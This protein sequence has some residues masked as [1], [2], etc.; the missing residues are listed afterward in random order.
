MEAVSDYFTGLSS[1]SK[2][3]YSAKVTA[4]GLTSDPYIIPNESWVAQPDKVPDVSWSDM[5]LYLIQTPSA[6]TKEEIQVFV[7]SKL[8]VA[9][10][11]SYC[12]L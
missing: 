6:Y 8:S 9:K 10:Y 11:F 3:R 2:A 4:M 5:F 1:E 12:S 7:I